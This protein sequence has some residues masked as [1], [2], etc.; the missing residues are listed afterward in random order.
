VG[1]CR[2]LIIAGAV[3]LIGLAVLLAYLGRPYP[4]APGG[5]WTSVDRVAIGMTEAEAVAAVGMPPQSEFPG[6]PIEIGSSDTRRSLLWSGAE[7]DVWVFLDG[8]G[9]VVGRRGIGSPPPSWLGRVR[10]RLG[11]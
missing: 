9:R 11:L 6:D 8:N 1:A 4:P 2:R 10:T 3:G 7:C 5:W